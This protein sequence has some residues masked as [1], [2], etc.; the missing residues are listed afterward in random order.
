MG[1]P[2]RPSDECRLEEQA[3]EPFRV[4]VEPEGIGPVEPLGDIAREDHDEEPG[5]R[6]ADHRP[7]PAHEDQR[8]AEDDLDDAGQQHDEVGVDREPARNL[9]LE[10][11][12]LETSGDR[13]RRPRGRRRAPSEPLIERSRS[14]SQ[15]TYRRSTR[16][17]SHLRSDPVADRDGDAWK[18]TSTEPLVCA[19][20][21]TYNGQTR[22][23]G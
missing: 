2:E 5:H 8:E 4:G 15:P 13:Y 22:S 14:C 1:G 11:L 20:R 23:C 10:L 9:S 6:P 3:N 12:A 21:A 17:T 19:A 16:S 7:P 18:G